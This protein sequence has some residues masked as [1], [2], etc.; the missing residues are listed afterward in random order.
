MDDPDVKNFGRTT[1]EYQPPPV[2]EGP[3][4][5]LATPKKKEEIQELFS[6]LEAKANTPQ[7]RHT[8][9]KL[10]H[11][12]LQDHAGAQLLRHEANE[13]RH[14]LHHQELKKRSKRLQKEAVQRSWNLE[15]V[16]A[17]RE[18]RAPSRVHITHRSE[19]SLRIVILSDKLE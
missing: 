5:L 14:Q 17:A 16:K 15:Q 4:G 11:T 3:N 18:G 8:L 2:L 12:V 1:P 13:L 9:R 19:D 10:R 7:S 6:Q